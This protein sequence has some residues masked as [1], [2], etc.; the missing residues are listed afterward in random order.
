MRR[1]IFVFGGLFFLAVA[2][3]L[4][5]FFTRHPRS[6]P[7]TSSS[8]TQSGEGMLP[9]TVDKQ[10]P[11]H[12]VFRGCSGE[13][14]GGDPALN[15]LKNRIDE[16]PLYHKVSL[17]K[18]LELSQPR[19]TENRR[20]NH[21]PAED[22]A[23]IAKYE[24]LPVAV[25]GYLAGVKLMGEETTNCRHEENEMRDFH[26]WLVT[27]PDHGR[28]KSIVVEATPAIRSRHDSWTVRSLNQLVRQKQ[29][30]RISGWLM[31]DPEHP[32]DRGRTRAT[33]WEIH[34]IMR[35]EVER[36]GEWFRLS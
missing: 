35:I 14:S 4:F 24:G 7:Q 30:V 27:S 10:S 25:E 2:V 6:L 20:R 5:F 33:L 19:G 31:F 28:D 1:S 26:I 11:Q 34:P 21:W 36:N 18:I 17:I 32:E 23:L 12:S 15:R 22:V 13:G 9:E 3:S 16:A 8:F 29:K